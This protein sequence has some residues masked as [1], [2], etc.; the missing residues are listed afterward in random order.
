MKKVALIGASGRMGQEIE[1][2]IKNEP[3]LE[4]T[5]RVG[6]ADGELPSVADL[7]PDLVDVVIDFSI[8][9][10]FEGVLEWVVKNSKP[11][12]SGTTGLNDEHQSLLDQAGSE[13]P[14]LWS[15]NMSLGIAWLSEAIRLLAPL[16]S[17]FD[18]QI[19]ETHH[20]RKVDSPSGT[21]KH[22]QRILTANVDANAPAP[23]SIRG[24]G[25][26]GVHKIHAMSEEEVITLEHQ[27]LNRTVFARGAVK[28]ATWLLGQTAGRYQISDML[29][30]DLGS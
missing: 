27:A 30:T 26:F 21:A 10:L 19:E 28:A 6:N 1:E 12:V 8:I 4:V 7:D 24:G 11:L 17:T 25:V 18:F 3:G 5:Q 16:A 29:K 15:A 22:L 2:I 20:R 13:A 23:L 14:I 9:D